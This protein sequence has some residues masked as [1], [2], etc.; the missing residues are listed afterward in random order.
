MPHPEDMLQHSTAQ[1]ST[2][3]QHSRACADTLTR[4]L[5]VADEHPSPIHA[6]HLHLLHPSVQALLGILCRLPPAGGT[7]S[8]ALPPAPLIPLG[9]ERRL[10]RCNRC[11]G[12][13]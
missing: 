4:E 7:G 11:W 13:L 5:C 9:L 3:Q 2:A 12:L 10:R 8:P 6:P 1:Q